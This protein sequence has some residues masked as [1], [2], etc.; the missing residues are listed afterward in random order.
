[1]K[2]IKD[3]L[4]CLDFLNSNGLNDKIIKSIVKRIFLLAGEKSWLCGNKYRKNRMSNIFYRKAYSRVND[5]ER[6]QKSMIIFL[7]SSY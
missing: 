6:L 1:M 4:L 2:K 7:R 5:L 3:K